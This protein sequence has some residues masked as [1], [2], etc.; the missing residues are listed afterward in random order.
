MAAREADE[1][2]DRRIRFRIG[3]NIGDIII[4]D[5][6]IYG[7]GVNVA[8]RLEGLAE[9]G[10]ICIARNVYNQVKN[11]VAFGFEPMGTH[12]IKNIAEPV[13]VYRVGLGPGVALGP[14]PARWMQPRW[15][16][17]AALVV[18]LLVSAAGGAW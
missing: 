8:A 4:E 2:K 13:E 5:G 14:Q 7:D 18:L 9:P 1:S 16:L 17:G 11:K 6:D 10:G 12:R 15:R 3:I